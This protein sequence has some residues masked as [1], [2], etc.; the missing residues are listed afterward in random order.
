VAWVQPAER[1]EEQGEAEQQQQQ[2]QTFAVEEQLQCRV[3]SAMM[4]V[5]LSALLDFFF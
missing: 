3:A 1:R 4:Q 2:Q 5:T